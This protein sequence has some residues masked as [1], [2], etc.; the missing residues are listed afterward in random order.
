MDYTFLIQRSVLENWVPQARQKSKTGIVLS[1]D[2]LSVAQGHE[3][4]YYSH[5]L[6]QLL[7]KH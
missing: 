3:V 6:A 7:F 2:M 5:L 1:A 4:R